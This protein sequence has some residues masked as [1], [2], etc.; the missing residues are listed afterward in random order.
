MESIEMKE[1]IQEDILSSSTVEDSEDTNIVYIKEEDVKI[2][3]TENQ[4][5]YKFFCSSFA[6]SYLFLP[7]FFWYLRVEG[8]PRQ[9]C[10]RATLFIKV[11]FYN[12]T[13]F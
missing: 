8:E 3:I 1:E 10:V 2:E 5:K 12:S 4:G 11:I 6:S 13:G 7:L 9:P